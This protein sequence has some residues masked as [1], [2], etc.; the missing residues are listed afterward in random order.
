MEEFSEIPFSQLI[1]ALLDG[2][3]LF[4][5][6]FLPRLSDLEPQE[7]DALRDAWPRVPVRRR[8]ALL[9]EIEILCAKD[10]LLSF[11]DFAAFAA[12]DPD[13][14]VRLLAVRTLWEYE[15]PE[16]I[17]LLLSILRDDPGE[18]VRAAAAGA[19]GPYVFLGEI[20]EIPAARLNEIEDLLLD[21]L[22]GAQP[23]SVKR[24]ALEALGFSS[25]TEISAL[26]EKAFQSGDAGWIASALY[27]MG[28]SANEE[29]HPQ[30]LA[31]L[32][33]KNPLIRYEAA[34][35]AGELE[36][37]DAVPL[38]LELIED[39]DDNTRSASIW[40]LSQI[41]GEGI[42]EAF[43]D[44]YSEFEDQEELELLDLAMDNLIFTESLELKP[45]FDFPDMDDD[46]L[47][48]GYGEF[49]GELN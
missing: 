44:L 31:M 21:V 17:P 10:L 7:L 47:P 41:G 13:P 5:P 29:W 33:D 18:A 26:I 22:E 14:K 48:A 35:A 19:L 12:Q 30:V 39:P 20:E 27:A 11:T 43:E 2:E 4:P 49:D 36:I 6:G 40:S 45:F 1:D 46:G 32:E 16:F 8:Q 38:L 37:R 42:Q 15:A 34:R 23:V 9:E 28:R 3:T 25:R 24:P